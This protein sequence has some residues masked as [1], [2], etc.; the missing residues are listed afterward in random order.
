[1]IKYDNT[2]N[3]F[4]VAWRKAVRRVLNIPYDAHSN[5]IPLS[6]SNKLPFSDEICKRSARFILPCIQSVFVCSYYCQIRY[7]CRSL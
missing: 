2:I 6:V 1:M 4:D 7:F 3:E 5:F